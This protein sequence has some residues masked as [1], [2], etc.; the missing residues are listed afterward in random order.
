MKGLWLNVDDAIPRIRK[1]DSLLNQTSEIISHTPD[2]TNT[3][4]LV[5]HG[6]NWP[7]GPIAQQSSRTM[8]GVGWICYKGVIGDINCML[9]DYLEDSLKFFHSLEHESSGSYLIVVIIKGEI[10]I[11]TDPFSTHP[12]YLRHDSS[13]QISPQPESLSQGCLENPRNS[14]CLAVNNHLFGDAT[15]WDAVNRIPPGSIVKDRIVKRWFNHASKEGHVNEIFATLKHELSQLNHQ[16]RIIPLSGGFD[17]RLILAA[18]EEPNFGFTFGP[19]DTQ[20]RPI[21]RHFSHKFT[22]DYHEFSMLDIIHRQSAKDAGSMMFNGI[23]ASPFAEVL[24][25]F[26]Y[27]HER[28]DESGLYLGGLLGD[29][30]QRFTYLHK[31]GIISHFGKLFPLINL[32]GFNPRR[33]LRSK[34]KTL[35]P[36][37]LKSIIDDFDEFSD[38]YPLQQSWQYTL[39]QILRGRG[40]RYI[41]NGDTIMS[42]QFFT[43]VQPFF[44]PSVYRKLLTSKPI[45]AL[46]LK[47]MRNIWRPVPKEFKINSVWGFRPDTNPFIAR[48][49]FS[50]TLV[51]KRFF[52][53]NRDT[54]SDE[55]K[56]IE[57]TSD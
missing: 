28:W 24:N 46:G 34:Y 36:H 19:Q 1:L 57:W 35:S 37:G 47:T 29:V 6:A 23:C 10:T 15:L 17:S 22:T 38:T 42:R 4:H 49:K 5:N 52:G 25:A 45:H 43:P 18:T 56:N 39:Y 8:L 51:A 9:A 41:I 7:H 55:L 30:L 53:H 50:T 11:I 13:I 2:Q 48:M 44:F 16:K 27:I 20:D 32:A 54:Y 12:H 33:R 21:A 3:I 40:M 31:N 14:E 26:R